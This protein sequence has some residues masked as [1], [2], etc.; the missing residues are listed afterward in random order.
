MQ[1]SSY[2]FSEQKPDLS[3]KLNLFACSLDFWIPVPHFEQCDVARQAKNKVTPRESR[4]VYRLIITMS[5]KE[6][7]LCPICMADLGDVI[8]LQVHFD[9]E[10]SKEDPAVVK[11]LKARWLNL[12]FGGLFVL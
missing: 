9:E 1:K 7:F 4:S 5:V 2:C 11:N 8:Q 3:F 10:H 12:E 6:G